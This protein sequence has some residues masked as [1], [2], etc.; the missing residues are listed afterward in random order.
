MSSQQEEVISLSSS[1]RLRMEAK[2]A[3]AKLQH[4]RKE[5]DLKLETLALIAEQRL[6]K[7]RV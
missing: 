5:E 2:L 3:E 7:L 6:K 4:I 1:A